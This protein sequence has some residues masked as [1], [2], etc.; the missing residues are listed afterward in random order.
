MS[1]APHAIHRP[2]RAG[3]AETPEQAAAPSR[4]RRALAQVPPELGVLLL[5]AAVLNLWGLGLNGNA[6]EYYSATVH[7]MTQSW[8]SFIFGS[9][10]SAG[11]QTV[12]KPPLALWVQAASARV[13]GFS[14][15]SFLVPQALMGIAATALTYDFTRR[16]FGRVAGTIAGLTLALTPT[17]VAVFRHNN[18]DALLMLCSTVAVWALVKA[19]ED[20]RTRW[21]VVSGVAVGLGFETKMA[22]ALLVAPAIVAAWLWFRPDGLRRALG[23]LTAFGASAVAVGLA[24]PVLVWLTPAADR[25][26]ISGTSDNSIWSLILGYNGLGRVFGQ[27]GG[28]GGGMGG[29]PG[30]GM[31][32]GN[33][34][35]G[36]EAGPLRLLNEALGSQGGWLLGLALGGGLI[37]L[38]AT[39]LR[40][41]DARSAWLIA[42][43]GSFLTTAVAF[44]FASGIFH[45]YYVSALAPFTAALAGAGLGTALKG[46]RG[47]RVLGGAALV[48][49]AATEW[50][51]LNDATQLQ[52][53]RPV[54]V[55]GTLAAGA[56]LVL[57]GNQRVRLV[58]VAAGV[59]LLLAAPAV[60]SAQTLGHAT[61]GTF[62]TGGPASAA[63]MGGPGGGMG[64]MGAGGPPTGAMGGTPPAMPKG[65]T[66]PTGAM[67][68]GFTPPTGATTGGFTPPT[69]ATTGEG[70]G[71]GGGMGGTAVSTAAL[72]YVKANGG[73]TIAVSGQ[74]SAAS[75]IL[76]SNADVAG[77]GGFSGSESEVS[78]SWFADRVAGGKIR[79]VMTGSGGGMRD[80]RTGAT[81]VMTAVTANCKAVSSVSGLYDCQGQASALRAA[82]K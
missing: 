15:W 81:T 75:S 37:V 25:P 61:S 30:G 18:P 68:S 45:P 28:P 39:R 36:G 72:S 51:V 16:R 14:S 69:G 8:H 11:L 43:G 34:M 42:V 58:A 40:R 24:W 71:M 64:R 21:L 35:F 38:L 54:L 66:P 67:P 52:W 44:S 49:G 77:I 32:G 55:A 5:L 78:V 46:G 41:T 33:S 50:I 53:L 10:D 80:G 4:W 59:A 57:A 62:P 60:W 63:G 20:S 3:G 22:T 26:W 70:G 23:Q 2:H 82:A 47:L 65:F 17:A 9:F 29:G 48:A 1:T 56:A 19:L 27:S 12:D 6:N 31:G 73:G 76:A 7:S 79:W 13:F 74:Q